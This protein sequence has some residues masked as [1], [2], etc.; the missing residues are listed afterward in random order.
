MAGETWLLFEEGSDVKRRLD[1]AEARRMLEA[2]EVYECEQCSSPGVV[3]LHP[4][5]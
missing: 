4:L 1:E 3:A 5:G 2:E